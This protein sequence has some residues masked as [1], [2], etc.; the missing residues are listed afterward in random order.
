MAVSTG[1]RRTAVA[2]VPLLVIGGFALVGGH[3]AAAGSALGVLMLVLFFAGG[4]APMLLA[5][6]A[7][8]GP[9]FLL[10]AMGYVLRVVLLL[11]ALLAFQHRSWLDRPA[12]AATIIAGALAWTGWLVQRHLRSRQPTLEI[13]DPAPVPASAVVR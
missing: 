11:A 4:R 12:L 6:T 10:V 1:T 5:R 13:A 8:A 7:P 2:A 3:R 9:L